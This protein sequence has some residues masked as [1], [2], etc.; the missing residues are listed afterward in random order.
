VQ[1][2]RYGNEVWNAVRVPPFP[3]LLPIQPKLAV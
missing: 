2:I 3:P 1:D